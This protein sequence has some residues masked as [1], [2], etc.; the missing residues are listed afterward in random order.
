MV[1]VTVIA[2]DESAA[3]ADQV[4]LASEGAIVVAA[5]DAVAAMA[6]VATATPSRRLL[7]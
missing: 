7:E 5:D 6:E 2:S 3:M 4:V 1:G